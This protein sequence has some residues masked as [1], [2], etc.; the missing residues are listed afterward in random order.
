MADA[1]A[2]AESGE[3][4]DFGKRAQGEDVVVLAEESHGVG[5]IVALGV[6]SVGLV[7]NHEDVA[8]NFLEEG[9]EFFVAE[10]CAG[11]IV[12]I[13]DVDD[14]GLR[15]NGGRDGVQIEGVLLHRGLD[16]LRA[17][18]ANRDGEKR[19]R[20]FAGD[21]VEAGAKERA[22][23]EIDDLAGAQADED[24]FEANVIATSQNFTETF[25]AAVGIPVRFAESTARGL[26]GFGGG[27][28]G[29]LVGSEFDGV[30]FEFLLDFFDRLAG[31]IGR[32]ALDVIGDKLFEG[33]RHEFSL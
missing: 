32:E 24:F 9:R 20:A 22:G 28:Q 19:E 12:G 5:K 6:F 23:S 1:V 3:A 18:G 7:E 11:G 15:G 21:A 2:D 10:G 27:T 33:V 16:E 4:V 25:A 8:R 14:T 13:G 17:A 30:D 26:H 29:I 31:N